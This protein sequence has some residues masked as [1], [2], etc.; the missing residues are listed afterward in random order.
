MSSL[1]NLTPFDHR[2]FA[3]IVKGVETGIRCN[4]LSP[5]TTDFSR[6]CAM[7]PGINYANYYAWCAALGETTSFPNPGGVNAGDFNEVWPYFLFGTV[8][9]GYYANHLAKLGDWANPNYA[10]NVSGEFSAVSYF[11]A[12]DIAQI[13]YAQA[14]GTVRDVVRVAGLPSG[15]GYANSKTDL[16]F[17]GGG[18]SGAAGYGVA[19]D[20]RLVDFVITNAGSG[21]TT[22]PTVT[23]PNPDLNKIYSVTVNNG[24][25]NYSPNTVATITGGNGSGATVR[26]K[27]LNGVITG[28]VVTDQGSGY[29]GT[30]TIVLSNT[31]RGSGASFTIVKTSSVTALTSV[32]SRALSSVNLVTGGFGNHKGYTDTPEVWIA[33][34]N[35]GVDA[36][37]SASI[38]GGR[39][40]AVSLDNAGSKYPTVTPNF[41]GMN[42]NFMTIIGGS[43]VLSLVPISDDTLSTCSS[44]ASTSI[45]KHTVEFKF[46]RLGTP[47]P[48]RLHW[49]ICEL[50]YTTSAGVT[51]FTTTYVSSD[52]VEI[53][54]ADGD[55]ETASFFVEAAA[56][57]VYIVNKFRIEVP[58]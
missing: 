49:D 10:A 18:G 45:E 27:T 30:P 34:G 40:S 9:S 21:Y 58:I 54:A 7:G 15:I 39:V 29:T 8:E 43:F 26:L 33:G 13:G 28:V 52:S 11:A 12:N 32:L 16:V 36:A 1:Y 46:R 41:L 23:C 48:M 14:S 17:S 5:T 38:S 4:G 25:S 53:S 35:G 37:A 22:N 20:G 47:I 42:V 24:G 6:I 51:T 55:A 31:T 56:D 50:A 2:P 19:V 3:V 44:P 57:K